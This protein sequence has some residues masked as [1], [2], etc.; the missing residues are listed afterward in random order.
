MKAPCI[1]ANLAKIKE[2]A[3]YILTACEQNG[4]RMAAVT[5]AVCAHMPFVEALLEVGVP[6]LADSRVQNLARLPQTLPRLSLRSSDPALAHETVLHSEYSLQ[7]ELKAIFALGRAARGLGKRHSVI[8][9]IDLGDLREGLYH[10]DKAGLTRAAQAVKEEP[11]LALAGVGTNL[12]CFGGIL[13]DDENLGTLI[14]IAR[15]LRQELDLPIPIIS[16]G[17]SSSLHLLFQGRLPKGINHLRIGEGLLL[18]RDTAN[19]RPFPFLHQDAFTLVARLVEVQDKPSKPEGTSGPNAFGEYATFPDLG[20]MRR[21]ILAIGR[22][23]TDAQG[24]NPR[25]ERVRILGASSD[26]LIVDLSLAPE[27]QV[28]DALAF[29]PDYGA[30]LKAYTSP[31]VLHERE[32]EEWTRFW[33]WRWA[34]MPLRK[35]GERPPQK[36]S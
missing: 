25:D 33:W 1:I 7:S 36:S 21:G 14:G 8:L 34:A 19:G 20:N 22:Q 2:N 17:N 27:Y 35:R 16:G 12:T 4:V 13:P 15:S 30:L 5:K 9:S 3:R 29:T 26:H 31:Y 11:W 6:M 10:R 32:E 23:D 24:L 28:G 18:G